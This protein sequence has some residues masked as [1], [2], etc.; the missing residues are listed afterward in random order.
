MG[1]MAQ[2]TTS[3]E[4]S[5][6]SPR[7]LVWLLIVAGLAF[8]IG[9]GLLWWRSVYSSP[10]HVFEGMLNNS[11]KVNG[12][13]RKVTQSS[14]GQ[15]VL[16]IS[17][18]NLNGKPIVHSQTTLTQGEPTTTVVTENIGTPNDDY[19]RYTSIKTSQTKPSGETLDFTS[20]L[21]V[22]GKSDTGAAPTTTDGDSYNEAV[23]GVVPFGK[24]SKAH[25]QELLKMMHDTNVYEV[26]YANVR[27]VTENG[28]PRYVYSVTVDAV[29]YV[30]LLKRFGELTGLNHLGDLDPNVYAGSGRLPFVLTVDVRSHELAKIEYADGQRVETLSGYNASHEVTIPTNAIGTDEL[31]ARL[32]ALQQ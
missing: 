21:N 24:L 16:Q 5:G 13:T 10:H 15:S 9:F 1:A 23:L 14:N 2:T 12:V 25:R 26:D 4:V 19:V 27:R 11:L 17:Q 30:T 6:S 22:W 8:F 3:S 18:L 32:Q 20:I 29:A 31:Q 7:S 28:R